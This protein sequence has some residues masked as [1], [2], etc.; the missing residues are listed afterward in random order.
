M[1]SAANNRKH[2]HKTASHLYVVILPLFG[3]LL[4]ILESPPHYHLLFSVKD[5]GGGASRRIP[6]ANEE[7]NGSTSVKTDQVPLQRWLNLNSTPFHT[8]G[9][10][11]SSQRREG[12]AGSPRDA[13]L[14][15]EGAGRSSLG[16]KA[17]LGS[18]VLP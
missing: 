11:T 6:A 1:P 3:K 12:Q 8:T 16:Y 13:A 4:I 15:W 18:L 7:G 2:S 10:W 5:C 17:K 9:A 14:A